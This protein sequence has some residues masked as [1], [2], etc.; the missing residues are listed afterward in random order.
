MPSITPIRQT[1]Q[2]G[3][4]EDV[5]AILLPPNAWSDGLNVE[6]DDGSVSKI[7][8]HTEL[9]DLDQEPLHVTFW[10]RPVTS[11]WVYCTDTEVYRVDS[12]GNVSM[13]GTGFTSGGSW[14]STV[15]N[16]GYT[17][18]LNNGIDKPHYITYG[19]GGGT[20][21]TTLQPL[22]GWPDD[23]SCGVI[24]AI[25]FALIAGNLK[26]SPV[27]SAVTDMA[28]TVAISSGAAVGGIPDEWAIGDFGDR[29][30]T[31]TQP[32][33]DTF[34]LSDSSPIQDFIVSRGAVFVLSK[35]SIGSIRPNPNSTGA[36]SSFI[37][38]TGYGVI[39]SGAATEFDGRVFAV[40]Q[41]DIYTTD[42][43]GAIQSV[44]DSK[45]RRFFREDLNTSFT[46]NIFVVRNLARDQMVVAYPS[47]RSSGP[48]DRALV[49]NYRY[50][51]WSKRELPNAISGA[52]GPRVVN[53]LFDEGSEYFVFN[54][55]TSSSTSSNTSFLMV[56]DVTD[57][58]NGED[59]T[60]FVERKNMDMG[61]LQASKWSGEV[62]VLANGTSELNF[63]IK[64][65]NIY[66]NEVDLTA[67]A[68]NRFNIS[69]DNKVN[70]RSNGKLFNVR[71][72]STDSGNWTLAGYS[73][74][75][76]EAGRRGT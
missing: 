22:P 58:F 70:P 47:I 30:V 40:D 68:D 14:Q 33:I 57:Q 18:I 53:N 16:G 56:G 20:D 48:C 64:G 32:Y 15:F 4:V 46:D 37:I 45:V 76:E 44:S 55:Y 25:N 29:G 2:I 1:G 41:N 12:A 26:Y 10:N 17:L 7:K 3:I 71:V 67:A 28:G 42:G 73:L 6:F 23:Y 61:D 38:N 27:G 65:S 8:G 74:Y 66:G 9:Y 43:S 13:I 31:T 50:N 72:T 60:A 63:Q 35:N 75:T 34:E 52:I 19:Q 54:G 51:T 11:Y 39:T 5:E 24:R 49:W 62:H 59:F 21:E 69:K 36:T